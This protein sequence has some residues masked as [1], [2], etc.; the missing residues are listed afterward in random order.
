MKAWLLKIYRRLFVR[1][2]YFRWH[3]MLHS[4][5]LRGMGMFNYEDERVSGEDWLMRALA[6]I[7]ERPVVL[8]VGANEGSYAAKLKERLAGARVICFEPHPKTFARLSVRA[9]ACGFETMNMGCSDVPGSAELFDYREGGGSEHASLYSQVIE[10]TGK[11]GERIEIKLTSVDEYTA[12]A[13]IDHINLLKIDTEG[14]E[15]KVLKGASRMLERG[16]IDVIQF[17]FNE[18]NVISRVFFRDFVEVLP[19]Y[20]LYRLLPDGL[21]SLEPYQPWTCEIFGFQNVLAV[22]KQAEARVRE[23]LHVQ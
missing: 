22:R 15:L 11:Q 7:W 14:N 8:D 10:Q 19:Q 6:Q 16:A 17:E 23:A 20:C 5:G 2:A 13:G 21:V 18:M 4:V 3:R 1:R 12:S 9:K